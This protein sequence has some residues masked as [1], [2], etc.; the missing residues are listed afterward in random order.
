MSSH[1][2][3]RTAAEIARDGDF[4]TKGCGVD[5][6]ATFMLCQRSI[7]VTCSTGHAG[8]NPSAR[9][10]CGLGRSR[11]KS[12]SKELAREVMDGSAVSV[13]PHA[14]MISKEVLQSLFPPGSAQK[15]TARTGAP[16]G[17]RLPRSKCMRG[18]ARRVW[19][20]GWASHRLELT[21]TSPLIDLCTPVGKHTRG[22]PGKSRS[23]DGQGRRSV[24][25]DKAGDHV[26]QHDARPALAR[27]A[28]THQAPVGYSPRGV[29][30]RAFFVRDLI[31]SRGGFKTPSG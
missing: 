7:H 28:P 31:R 8:W 27:S 19:L 14:G 5:E 17:S 9:L 15:D 12:S 30:A 18:M 16:G 23:C 21:A 4:I 1:I 22:R 6:M 13:G 10:P 24:V 20:A 25:T 11:P 29:S 3:C 26:T 2:R